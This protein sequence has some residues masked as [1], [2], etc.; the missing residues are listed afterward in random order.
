MPHLHPV[1]YLGWPV[2]DHGH[3]G[4]P[5]A[6]LQALGAAASA[7][8]SAFGGSGDGHIGVVDAL[9]DRLGAQVPAGLVGEAIA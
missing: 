6:P 8:A 5:P 3:C 9:V 1:V 7:A 2:G 4:Q